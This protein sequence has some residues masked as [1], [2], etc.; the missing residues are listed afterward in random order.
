MNPF[1]ESTSAELLPCQAGRAPRSPWA[2]MRARGGRHALRRVMGA[3]LVTAG[4]GFAT[5]QAHALDVNQAN[6]QQLETIRGIGP[7]TAEVIIAERERGGKFESF[8]DLAERV[9]GIGQKKAQALQAA[10][11]QVGDGEPS[12]AMGKGAAGG[13]TEAA[14]PGEGKPGEGKPAAG[15]GAGAA[16]K[17]GARAAG[18]SAGVPAGASGSAAAVRP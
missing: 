14:K 6:A 3:L 7:R 9:R 12:S 11:L 5:P 15:A 1:I 2:A 18:K 17:S 4:L 16:A 8:E 13:T 10:G